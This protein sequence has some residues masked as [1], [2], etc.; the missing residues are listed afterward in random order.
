MKIVLICTEMNPV[1]PIIGGAVQIYIDGIVPY[2][3]KK[4]DVTVLGIKHESLPDNEERDGVV[5][6]RFPKDRYP[7]HIAHHLASSSY[8]ILHI[9]N[10]PQF[11]LDYHHASPGSKLI[12]SL[13]NEMM[14]EHKIPF[15][16]GKQTVAVCDAMLTVSKYIRKTV[17]ERFP[18]AKK[19][20]FAVYSAADIDRYKPYWMDQQMQQVRDMMRREYGV[21]D[22]QVI[23][24]VGRLSKVKGVDVLIQSMEQVVKLWPKA[25]LLIVGSKWFGSN[26]TDPYVESLYKAA[27]AFP[28]H[29]RF[30]HFVPPSEMPGFFAMADLFVCPSQ[31]NEP[32]AR[33]HYEAMASGIPIISTDRGG[34]GEVIK[35]GK[36]GLLLSKEKYQNPKELAKL[37]V[38]L[39]KHP[40]LANRLAREGRL[41][42]EKKFNFARLSNEIRDIYHSISRKKK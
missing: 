41:A 15:E 38:H 19:K 5:Y 33:V 31:W 17:L 11:V 8:D 30:A 3:A 34:N 29:I 42:A 21:E 12:L 26:E 2:L 1:P 23:L 35:H 6:H 28:N 20:L 22:R 10:R 24:F 27:A 37:I 7:V 9:F 4:W 13:H 25:F 14:A 18:E 39:L 32:L 36:T 40:K 16:R